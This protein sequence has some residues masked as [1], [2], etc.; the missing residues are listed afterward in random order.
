[1][2]WTNLEYELVMRDDD[3]TEVVLKSGKAVRTEH[4]GVVTFFPLDLN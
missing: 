4:E 3:G 2:T 1:V